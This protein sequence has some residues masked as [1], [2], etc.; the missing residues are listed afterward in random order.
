MA[1]N[2]FGLD[3]A[4][5][6]DKLS[7]VLRDLSH[8]T[9]EELARALA[10]MARTACEGVL[11]EAEF[12]VQ[13]APTCAA[14]DGDAQLDAMRRSGLSIDGDNAYKRD[15]ID[16]IVG[17]LMLGKQGVNPPPAGHWLE[18]FWQT[19]RGEGEIQEQLAAAP[20]V[21]VAQEP[22]PVSGVVLRDGQPTLLMEKFVKPTDQ[23]LYTA[24][25]AAE[26][27]DDTAMLGVL[28]LLRKRR[29]LDGDARYLFG[30]DRVWAEKADAFL[31]ST[32]AEQPAA[33]KL[34]QSAPDELRARCDGGTCGLGGVCENCMMADAIELAA[35]PDAVAVPREL[36]AE[37]ESIIESYAEALKAGHAPGSDWD[38]EEAA[39]D[40]YE[41]EAG[42]AAKLRALL[43]KEGE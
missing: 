38:G 16:C 10:R 22:P 21:P 39:Q 41:R 34:A 1:T 15:L 11:G 25:P 36:L 32:A 42:V 18:Q 19:A 13:A 40:D 24:P 3:A 17:A 4:Y 28:E 37:A 20:A 14:Q 29:D 26:Q 35:E 5:F 23:R 6:S 43:G 9:P 27:P 30:D 12:T 7:L 2:S 8:F 31:V 33:E